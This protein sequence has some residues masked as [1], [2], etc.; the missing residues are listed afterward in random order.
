[1]VAAVPLSAR[2]TQKEAAVTCM[3][4]NIRFITSKDQGERAWTVRRDAIINMF[5]DIRPDV[6]GIQEQSKESVDWLMENL[7]DYEFYVPDYEEG[8]TLPKGFSMVILWNKDRFEVKDC[9][10]FFLSDTP[11]EVSK[12]W[13]SNH[14]RNTAWVLLKDR[15]TGRKFYCFDTHLDHRGPLAKEN[16][17]LTNVEMVRKIAGKRS[18]VIL[19]GD[20]NMVRSGQQGLFLDPFYDYMQSAGDTALEIDR[21]K[22]F[23]GYNEDSST[24]RLLD[25]IFYR[26]AE[27]DKFDVIDS[28]DYGV[29]FISDHY[30]IM[31]YFRL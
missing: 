23:N 3:S 15:Q 25:Y 19:M 21:A 9:G 27:A 12:G 29:R 10:R 31:T 30:P 24:H 5:D 16:G 17:V 20:M 18:S 7:P 28:P 6:V 26:N 11:D 1:M 8:I 22:T 4:F 14:Y 2:K 13:D